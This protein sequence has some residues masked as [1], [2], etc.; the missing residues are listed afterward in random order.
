MLIRG[1]L[2]VGKTTVGKRLAQRLSGEH[3]EVE[4]LL[5][6]LGVNELVDGRIPVESFQRA[7]DCAMPRAL[8]TLAAGGVVIFEGCFYQREVIDHLVGGLPYPH[9]AFTLKA[10]VE[11]CIQ[12]DSGRER[13]FGERAAREVHE[14]VAR[15][16]H[17]VG[18]DASGSAEEAVEHILSLL[19]VE[20]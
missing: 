1:A 18:I 6:A 4:G 20:G 7:Y 15:F 17:G 14:L 2:G 13:S 3:V 19:P 11:V 9:H 16:D 8:E 5:D 10:P 12:R